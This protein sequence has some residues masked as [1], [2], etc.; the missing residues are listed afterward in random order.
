MKRLRRVIYTPTNLNQNILYRLEHNDNTLIRI[1]FSSRNLG[2]TGV[3]TL[4]R[5][6]EGNTHLNALDLSS[7][8]IEMEGAM[9][10]ASLLMHQGRNHRDCDDRNIMSDITTY[11]NHS[12][13]S[14]SNNRGIR[15]LILG[16]N[17]LLDEGVNA[18]AH[19]LESNQLLESLMLDDN[20]IGARGLEVLAN[21]LRKNYKLERLH[22][23]HNSFQSLAPL[24]SCLFNKSSLDDV[25]DSNHSIKHIFLNCGY[26]YE[27]REL[28][29]LL[30]INRLGRVEARRKK[31]AL[32]LE[33]DL[34][35]LFEMDVDA[36]L[37]PDVL[38]VLARGGSLN[39]V[40]GVVK[41][42]PSTI[43]TL[44]DVEGHGEDSMEI[45]YL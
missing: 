19:A 32:Y 15:T 6:L 24:I 12:I 40:F 4:M 21:S 44:C 16:D 5:A 1:I 27:S 23:R 28:E 25:V 2:D 43:L 3:N 14:N 11:N 17:N 9:S 42:L 26:L 30:K 36:R 29:A 38:G 18:I 33:E 8:Q 22:L 34:G 35:R 45:E 39:G 37:C 13:M 10:I 7:N 31:V 20:C 41:N